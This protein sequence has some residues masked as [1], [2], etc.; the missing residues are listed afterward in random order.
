VRIN[1]NDR[2]GGEVKMRGERC[3]YIKLCVCYS[4]HQGEHKNTPDQDRGREHLHILKGKK[5]IALKM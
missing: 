5:L 3:R 4:E 1:I 2:V